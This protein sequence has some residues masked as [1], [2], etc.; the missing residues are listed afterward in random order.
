M[1]GKPYGGTATLFGLAA[2]LGLAGCTVPPG[3]LELSGTPRVVAGDLI[4]LAGHSLRLDGIDAPAPGQRCAFR[5]KLYDCGEIARAALLDLT[6]GTEV[7]CRTLESPGKSSGG[8]VAAA[9]CSA[10]GY[11]LS[12]G[13]VYTG[14]ALVLPEGEARYGAQQRR[15]ESRKHG[16][17]RGR[18]VA[19]WD[20][21][22]GERLPEERSGG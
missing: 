10:Q 5:N 22:R 1:A 18:F 6:A 21:D 4:E 17:W 13:M 11:D 15:A 19:P 2:C 8:P 14:W 7:V 3:G 9:R 20:W 16:L 12:E